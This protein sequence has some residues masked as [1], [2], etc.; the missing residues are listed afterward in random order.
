[1]ESL[2]LTPRLAGLAALV[3]Q[4][5]RL[6]DIGTDHG[7][8][9]LSLLLSGRIA[10]AIGS[11]IGAGP[12]EHAAH[13]AAEHGVSLS[14]RLAPGLDAI[15]PEECDTISVAGMGGQTIAEIL[16]AAPWTARG[17][18]L[19][20]LQPMTKIYELRQ[21]LWEHGYD[22]QQ[23]T[24]CREDRRRYVILSVRGGA[25]CR[26]RA[27]AQ[28]VCSPALLRAEGAEDYLTWLLSRERHVLDGMQQ[29]NV[30]D[31]AQLTQQRRLISV[32]E[33]A[34]EALI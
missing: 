8:L 31:A 21:W 1:M 23:E 5:A 32:L 13:N 6:A 29:A 11:D 2:V 17:D 14:L 4:H 18:H 34:R 16:A 30:T 9:P 26:S 24:I 10:S 28:C 20:L 12:L 22:I 3:P 19:L 27:L 7:K 25:A 33:Q 15:R